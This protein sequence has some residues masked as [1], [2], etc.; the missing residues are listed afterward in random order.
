MLKVV[1]FESVL[2]K[3]HGATTRVSLR[4]T[5]ASPD[6]FKGWLALCTC[7]ARVADR[8]LSG[9]ELAVVTP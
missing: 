9:A 3:Y 2:L 6:R 5:L 7:P 1:G 8:E 4:G